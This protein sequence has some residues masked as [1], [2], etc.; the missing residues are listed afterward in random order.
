MQQS[1]LSASEVEK[2]RRERAVFEQFAASAGLIVVPGSLQQLRPPA[3]DI[4]VELSTLGRV[5]F[6]L[7]RINNP[8]QLAVN[9]LRQQSRILLNAEFAKLDPQRRGRL[10]S[11][12]VDGII[13]FFFRGTCS[14][15]ERRTALPFV[16]DELKIL[17]PGYKGK[18]DLY[19]KSPPAALE[20]VYISRAKTF[21]HLEFQCFSCGFVPLPC[22]DEIAGKLAKSY[23]CAEPLELIA[24][25]EFG[26]LAHARSEGDLK[27]LVTCILPSSRFRRVWVFEQL[28]RRNV[29][30]FARE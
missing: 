29:L 23:D 12:Y 27:E 3:P 2:H 30:V 6:E 15:A 19:G 16:W 21:G 18:L 10:S 5:A 7:V 17:P 22:L 8:E 24:Y 20:L 26:E 28:L 13:T 4:I 14:L 9:S 25:L 1:E 11:L